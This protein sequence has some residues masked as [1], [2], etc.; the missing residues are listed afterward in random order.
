ME[1]AEGLL[2]FLTMAFGIVIGIISL[3]KGPAMGVF[4]V[5]SGKA[6]IDQSQFPKYYKFLAITLV[7]CLILGLMITRDLDLVIKFTGLN[8]L[9]A[10]MMGSWIFLFR[11]KEEIKK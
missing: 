8:M 11:Y 3:I 2:L 7:S 5:L 4:S 10:A 9:L 1:N 6:D